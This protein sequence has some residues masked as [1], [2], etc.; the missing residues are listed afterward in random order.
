MRQL[1]RL[2]PEARRVVKFALVGVANTCIALASYAILVAIGVSYV[3]AGPI[4]WSLGVLHGYTWNRIWTFESASHH[5]GLMT[6]YVAVGV[7]G[8]LLNTGLL[9]L[10]VAVLGAGKLPAEV[11]AL[12]IVVL[13]TFALNRY[14]VFAEHLRGRP[15]ARL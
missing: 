11:V 3:V 10:F 13:T 5:T 2:T 12:P 6:R 4:G 7:V 15:A 9:A 1:E 8:L 14:W